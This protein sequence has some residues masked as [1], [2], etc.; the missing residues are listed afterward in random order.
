MS[1][2]IITIMIILSSMMIGCGKQERP[3]NMPQLYPCIITITQEE[4][5]VEGV[6]ISLDSQGETPVWPVSGKTDASGQARLVTLGKY[7]GI[8]SGQYKVI[9]QK[10]EIEGH[11][12]AEG[13]S[14]T[15]YIKTFS[16]INPEYIE[17][18]KTPLTLNMPSK[19]Y[20]TSFE[21]G[22]Q[23]RVLIESRDTHS[24]QP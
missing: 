8:P 14:P 5:P 9:V 17:S 12:G 21:L 20:A 15:R 13:V 11:F 1:I 6:E 23:T 10:M 2:R 22:K 4:K 16:L 7:P 24:K 3:S 18:Q 19:K